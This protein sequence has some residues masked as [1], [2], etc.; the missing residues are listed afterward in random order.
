MELLDGLGPA[1]MQERWVQAKRQ[2]TLD[3]FSFMLEPKTFRSVPTDW[4]PRVIQKEQWDHIGKG[5]EQRLKAIN[6]FLS[7]LYVGTQTIVPDDVIYTCQ[8]FYPEYQGFRPAKDVFVHIYGIDLVNVGNGE[9]AVLEDNLRI[10]SGI[11]YQLKTVDIAQRVQPELADAYDIVRYDIKD[12]YLDLFASLCEKESPTCVILTDSKF[13]AA[14]F[15]HRYLAD[16]LEIPL[17]EG[18]DLYI[19]PDGKVYAKNLDG[20]VEIDLIYRRV[21]DLEIFVPGLTEAYLQNKVVMVNGMGTSA[22]DDKLVFLWV[23]EMIRHY[24]G[25]EPILQQATSYDLNHTESLRYVLENLDRLVLKIRQGYG[26]LGVYI[27]P[28]LDLSYRSRMARNIIEQP[29]AYIAQETL[30]FSKHLIF[31]ESTGSFEERYVDLRVF[32]IQ[33]GRGEAHAFPGGLTRVA[34]ANSRITNNSS[35]GLCKPTW[36]IR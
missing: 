22:D 4:I 33:N 6:H 15:E 10:P 12:A 2:V 3:G 23:P 9:Y 30:D 25:E 36:V 32:A 27:M 5:V 7:D 19:G 17:V 20:D 14:F 18:F 21:E 34:N 1:T 13:G 29:R 35:G 16:L 28:D 26:G 11:A 24:L 31:D 8:Y